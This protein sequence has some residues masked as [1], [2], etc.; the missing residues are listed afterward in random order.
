MQ[1]LRP[2]RFLCVR[3]LLPRVQ[4]QHSVST[5]RVT[6]NGIGIETGLKPGSGSEFSGFVNADYS[7]LTGMDMHGKLATN[8]SVEGKLGLNKVGGLAG[9][10]LNIKASQSVIGPGG[11]IGLE[12][13]NPVYSL[14]LHLHGETP[15]AQPRQFRTSFETTGSL[16]VGGTG[17]SVAGQTKVGLTGGE[18]LEYNVGAEYGHGPSTF[19]LSTAKKFESLIASYFVKA[20]PSVDLGVTVDA[21][22]PT[23]VGTLAVGSEYRLD[24]DTTLKVKA[25]T[26]RLVSTSVE[27]RLFNPML[28]MGVASEIDVKSGLEANRFGLSLTLGDFAW[29]S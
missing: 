22:L 19:T 7:T 26:D 10:L 1:N 29:A 14:G 9:L 25:D 17:V 6:K 20:V 28:R 8:G 2:S 21:S 18:L 16:N 27:H 24:R 11:L 12:Y 4:L 15:L 23:G 13:T 5:R 3:P